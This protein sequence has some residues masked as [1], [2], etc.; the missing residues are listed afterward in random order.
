MNTAQG[1]LVLVGM[2]TDQPQIFFN[3]QAVEGVHSIQVVNNTTKRQVVLTLDEPLQELVD[4]G[5]TI[6]RGL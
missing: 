6:K 2:N 3:G 5:I 1:S 4:A